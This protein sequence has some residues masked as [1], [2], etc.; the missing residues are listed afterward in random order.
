MKQSLTYQEIEV[1]P[2]YDQVSLAT[3]L[4]CSVEELLNKVTIGS[5][6][7]VIREYHQLSIYTVNLEWCIQLFDL[8][9]S[10]NDDILCSYENS[11]HELIDVL[12]VTTS[13]I[14]ERFLNKSF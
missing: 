12:Y 7:S 4:K 5:L 2:Y 8:D 3:D 11:R 13:W 14:Y 1:L 10:A 6:I 9:E